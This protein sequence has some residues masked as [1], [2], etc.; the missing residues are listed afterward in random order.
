[1]AR[2]HVLA[3]AYAGSLGGR[4]L[5]DLLAAYLLRRDGWRADGDGV[6]VLVVAAAN[7]TDVPTSRSEAR[8]TVVHA[9]DRSRATFD[10][11]DVR[12][13]GQGFAD[14]I[15][16]MFAN[17]HPAV[18]LIAINANEQVTGMIRRAE[19]AKKFGERGPA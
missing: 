3:C 19:D 5:A 9:V 15:F 8:R 12:S 10:F 6:R 13:V 16:R 14:E 17:E 2:D 7:G 18:K 11:A 4:P 1:M